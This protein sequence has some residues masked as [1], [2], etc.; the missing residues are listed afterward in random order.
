MMHYK[1]YSQSI[2]LYMKSKQLPL[3]QKCIC[4]TILSF[5][6]VHKIKS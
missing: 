2:D 5:D 6:S 4:S 1:M 3:I